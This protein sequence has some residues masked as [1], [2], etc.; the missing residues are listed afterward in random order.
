MNSGVPQEA[1]RGADYAIAWL[2]GVLLA[3]LTYLVCFIISLAIIFRVLYDP[4]TDPADSIMSSGVVLFSICALLAGLAGAWLAARMGLRKRA[5][6]TQVWMLVGG[7]ALLG[8]VLLVP[9]LWGNVPAMLVQVVGLVIGTTCGAL[10]ALKGGRRRG[11][12]S[13]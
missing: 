7:I 6:A 4:L 13:A 9:G 11:S 3:L 1:P 12:V 5:T 2:V 8:V 10:L